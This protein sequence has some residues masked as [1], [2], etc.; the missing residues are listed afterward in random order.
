M[1]V[2][3]QF[4]IALCFNNFKKKNKINKMSI[5]NKKQYQQFKE[6]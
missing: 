2:L 5:E 4:A 6:I 3:V 1:K